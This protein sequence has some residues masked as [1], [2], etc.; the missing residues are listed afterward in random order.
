MN[1]VTENEKF[2]SISPFSRKKFRGIIGEMR[3]N[4]KDFNKACLSLSFPY[5]FYT[6]FTQNYILYV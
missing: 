3:K 2:P 5:S 4:A 1:L 6:L